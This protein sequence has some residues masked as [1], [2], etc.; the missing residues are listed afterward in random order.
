MDF[1]F[2]IMYNSSVYPSKIQF[3]QK[4][5][6]VNLNPSPDQINHLIKPDFSSLISQEN[7][8]ISKTSYKTYK[9]PKPY[10]PI[11]KPKISN[12]SPYE[13][14]GKDLFGVKQKPNYFKKLNFDECGNYSNF[15]TNI[16]VDFTKIFTNEFNPGLN[17]EENFE[18]YN[19]HS[20]KKKRGLNI[21]KWKENN[22]RMENDYTIIKTIAENK[23]DAV[24][25]VKENRTNKIFCIKKISNKTNKNNFNTLIATLEDI[26]KEN[27]AWTFN[28]TFCLKYIDYW[29]ENKNFD[30]I[31][32]SINY[33]NKNIYILTDYYKNGDILDY[34]DKLDKKNYTFTYD[35]YWDMIFEM[36]IG[37]LYVHK[38][39]YIHFDIKPE[40][41][42][43]DNDGYLILNDFG[44]SRKKEELSNLVDIIEGDSKYISKELFDYL[45]NISLKKINNK[46]DIF[47]LGLT[48]L[49]ILAKIEL[50][51][52][53]K[54]WRY[55]RES[56]G[57]FLKE[58]ILINSNI[59]N[60]DNFFILIKKMISPI[61][62][63]PTLL[64]LI[65]ETPELNQR[66]RL[67]EQNI[68]K[69]SYK[70]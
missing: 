42:L 24:Y 51:S 40:N 17:C 19:E 64:E 46:T 68:Y 45:D 54:L 44:L 4:N 47:S 48:I 60:I 35:F 57:N 9:R 20:N 65:E 39:G 13:I 67:L 5:N 37:L 43:V 26:Q 12:P 66:F 59:D 8:F 41:Y 36:M 32:K 50:P 14:K 21:L 61:N 62:E 55:L 27:R 34:L 38:K 29:I 52:N 25:Q 53:G 10:S 69:K 56:G 1:I 58:K 70:L 3:N 22:N 2:F 63:R 49:E 7:N 28:K 33:L 6:L 31:K 16:S 15:S 30:L 18:E 23:L 11:K